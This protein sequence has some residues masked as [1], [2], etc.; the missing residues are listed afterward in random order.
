MS[1]G[2]PQRSNIN[3]KIY[4]TISSR[5]GNN[6]K[7][8]EKLPW[9]KV[10]SCLNQF[11]SLESTPLTDSFSQ[12]YGSTGKSGRLGVNQNGE[13]VYA[14]NINDSDGNSIG[15][16]R[17]FR[18]SPVIESVA[19]TQ[20]KEG[21]SKKTNFTIKAFSPGQVEALVQYFLEPGT[22]VLVEWG[23]NEVNSVR[24]KTEINA[25][26]ACNV[27]KYNN[28][29]HL[30]QK[31]KKSGG[32]YDAVLGI[33]TGGS[34]AFGDAETFN[35]DVEITS[36]GEIPAYL[37][38]H[39][40]IRTGDEYINNAGEMFT[41][42]DINT[43]ANDK[44]SVGKALFKQMY[45]DLPSH[46]QTEVI[47]NLEF[48]PWA[49]DEGNFVNMDKEIREKLI[50]ATKKADLHSEKKD[51]DG[52]DISIPTD[53]PLFDTD[54]F[55][56]AS[57][58]FT[59]LDLTHTLDLKPIRTGCEGD[60]VTTQNPYINWR[61]TII[62]AH[63]N[64]FST[65]GS[66][67][68]IPNKNT[69]DFDLASALGS[70]EETDKD[71]NKKFKKAP[72]ISFEGGGQGSK[73]KIKTPD[74]G[75]IPEGAECQFPQPTKIEYEGS[76]Q[77][78]TDYECISYKSF[79]WGYLKDLYINFD[80]FLSCITSPGMLSKDVY[81]RILN[82]LSGACNLMW[83]FQIIETGWAEPQD[84][85]DECLKWW[86]NKIEQECNP[87][88]NMLKIVCFNTT[89]N[90]TSELGKAKFQSRGVNSPF[91]S[92]ELNF[93]IPSAMKGQMVMQKN[94][95]KDAS[96]NPE[97]SD[98]DFRGLFGKYKDAVNQKLNPLRQ[99]D[100]E[101]REAEEKE[102][103]ERQ[104]EDE[105][106]KK[107]RGQLN[108]EKIK[109]KREKRKAERQA[110][111]DQKKSNYESFSKK[112]TVVPRFQY[113]EGD[114]DVRASFFDNPNNDANIEDIMMVVAYND[115]ELLKNV[116]DFNQG[117]IGAQFPDDD[118]RG[119]NAIVL[120]IKF[121]FTIHGI[122]GIKVGDCFNIT[123]LPGE[124]KKKI[125]TV[126]QVEHNIEQSIWK[127]NITS[128]LVPI[129]ASKDGF[130]DKVFNEDG[131][132]QVQ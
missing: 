40:N 16:D 12:R 93:D 81:Y 38:H 6:K 100:D 23:F 128:N 82:G 110:K 26:A 123:D 11:L 36:V 63:K 106:S 99:Q 65:D 13:D 90:K 70:G 127:T 121:N 9:I 37:Q 131:T 39:R 49:T 10:T 42:A 55:I 87:G 83:D 67:L 64:I 130:K 97:Q 125:F 86:R 41:I 132:N 53:T 66:K 111:E 98:K 44:A 28:I 30:T 129:D 69:P 45:N 51:S 75:T 32:T 78:D 91:L 14:N 101:A 33:V 27:A 48:Q 18:S 113:R 118:E 31:R 62:K 60:E 126:T 17:S 72:P 57:L 79:E 114:M 117:I 105:D 2:F 8:S 122:S 35:I 3:Q 1:I 95:S 59:I 21:L 29:N 24:Q 120:P 108:R 46:K 25:A 89:G 68:M 103:E 112:S 109:R 43:D 47:K 7:L 71:G 85:Q 115:T 61:N 96:P 74:N 34:M 94:S 124:Y 119:N 56:K 88:N 20:G 54:R 80:F 107:S 84:Y 50:E 4:K 19:V 104:R 92:A 52:D 102:Q 73:E 15:N 58:A 116:S 77:Y 22:N 76:K 5:A